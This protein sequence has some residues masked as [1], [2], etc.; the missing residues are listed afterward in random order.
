MEIASRLRL[1]NEESIFFFRLSFA[2]CRRR[3]FLLNQS[4]QPRTFIVT[5]SSLLAHLSIFA[6]LLRLIPMERLRSQR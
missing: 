4:I 5:V 3:F 2:A 1:Q 6:M